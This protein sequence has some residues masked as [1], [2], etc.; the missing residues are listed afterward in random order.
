MSG[1]DACGSSMPQL[2]VFKVPLGLMRENPWI[3]Y[4]HQVSLGSGVE[5]GS[6]GLQDI[7]VLSQLLG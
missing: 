5:N 2:T 3:W 7:S 1:V 6:A 4:P